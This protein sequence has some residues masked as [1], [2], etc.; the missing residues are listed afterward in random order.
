LQY[1][2]NLYITESILVVHNF[3]I[4]VRPLLP[5]KIAKSRKIPTKLD[6]RRHP[7]PRS[8]ILVSVERPGATSY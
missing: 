3:V 6:L 8:S 2:L 4:R 5:S 7:S 1:Q